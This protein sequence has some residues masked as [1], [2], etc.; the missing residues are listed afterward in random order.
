MNIR[1]LG[2]ASVAQEVGALR[3]SESSSREVTEV[4]ARLLDD[5]RTRGDAAV[6]EATARF[7]WP[8]ASVATLAVPA[9]ELE[10]AYREVDPA[11]IAA[12]Q[13][14]RDNCTFF[15]RH[16][17]VPDWEEEGAQGQR[18]GI[19]H[20]PVERAGLYVPGGLGA[21]AST[22]I[23]NAVPALV[24]GVK[25]LVICTP[26]GRDGR[27][28]QSIL[29]AARLVGV[30]RVFGVGGAQAIA[31]MAYG[32]E[33]IPKVDVICGPGNAYVMEAKRQVYGTVGIDSL[34]GPS[35]VLVVA[36]RTARPDWV[37][38]DLLAQEEHGM[39]ASAVLM[40]D[41]EALCGAVQE[42]LDALR[43]GAVPAP[44]AGASGSGEAADSEAAPSEA[45]D[46]R[47][48]AFYPAQGEDFLA[49][50]EALV[51]T[52]APEHLEI[53]VADPR[54]F[55]RRVRSAGA[56]FVGHL[57]PTAFGDYVAGSNHVLP[58]EGSARFASPLSVNTFMRRSSY[59][60]MTVE[61]VR[62]LTPHL[63]KIADSEGFTFHK[64]SAELRA[65]DGAS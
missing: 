15:H 60:E 61:A 7:D 51:N 42:E 41:S 12:L 27:V 26:P 50:A 13:T 58:T 1:P 45:A 16:E 23:M 30:S 56:V 43:D 53:E 5:I 3:P 4:V 44:A 52:Y 31:A 59:V 34:A 37:A 21:Y 29:A 39:G 64:A 19:R 36:D 48:A 9:E 35:E 14:S 46:S 8:Q 28:N 54:D 22:V 38:A 2:R 25:E 40:A 57:A 65:K 33:T 20:L 17:L 24:A 47:L 55:L 32:T 62:L 6:V 11:L 49:V 10:A 18:L 63:A